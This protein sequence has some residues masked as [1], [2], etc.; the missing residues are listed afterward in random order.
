[1]C[2]CRGFIGV[3]FSLRFFV[4]VVID[5]FRFS[6]RGLVLFLGRRVVCKDGEGKIYDVII[7]DYLL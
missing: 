1:M 7:G 6:G 5:S 4:R 2:F 3:F